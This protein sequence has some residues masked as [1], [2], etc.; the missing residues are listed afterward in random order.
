MTAVADDVKT[1]LSM[2]WVWAHASITLC[3]ALTSTSAMYSYYKPINKNNHTFKLPIF[4]LGFFGKMT[5]NYPQN[6]Q[7]Q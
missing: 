6:F 7:F 1:T 2:V 4:L 3:A 5:P